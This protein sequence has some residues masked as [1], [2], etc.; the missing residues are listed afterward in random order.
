MADLADVVSALAVSA[1]AAVYPSGTSNPPVAGGA[2]TIFHGWPT[3]ND[4]DLVVKNFNAAP[5]VPRTIVSI[6]PRPGMYRNTSRNPSKWRE[7]SRPTKTITAGIA[8]NAVTIGGA[9]PGLSGPAQ[10]VGLIIG[11]GRT[12][13]D[14][15][16]QT[17]TSD[18]LSTIATALAALVN[19]AT[20]ASA[21]GAV[22]TIPNAW[23]I[24]TRVGI[25]GVA[26]RELRRQEET[27]DVNIWAPSPG[28]RDQIAG[29]IRTAFAKFDFLTLADGFAA[30]VRAAGDNWMD[31]P[32][33]VGLYRR[34]LSFEVDYPTTESMPAAEIIVF[35]AQQNGGQTPA[36]A[37]TI[38]TII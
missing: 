29:P 35:E 28:L 3:P 31:D 24:A 13:R 38:T 5:S 6:Y 26:V 1:T 33:K 17:L 14:F 20:P 8:G 23:S 7:L 4:L 22:I 34:L 16:Y 15:V 37:P 10:N 18:T 9:A 12:K 36:A 30:R 25:T 27:V 32:E 11:Y 2:V 19:A 21:A